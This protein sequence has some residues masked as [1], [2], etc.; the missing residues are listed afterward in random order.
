MSFAVV[1]VSPH[2]FSA[3]FKDRDAAPIRSAS[4]HKKVYFKVAAAYNFCRVAAVKPVLNYLIMVEKM[5]LRLS[6]NS[7]LADPF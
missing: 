3:T 1:M 7:R 6:Q 5:G 2:R 4:R